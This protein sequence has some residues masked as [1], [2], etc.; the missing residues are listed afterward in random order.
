[1][2]DKPVNP[3]Y[4]FWG[5]RLNDVPD[6]ERDHKPLEAM[7][8]DKRLARNTL[9]T[10]FTLTLIISTV[11]MTV[12]W[13]NENA[14]QIITRILV[15]S[16]ILPPLIFITVQIF[17]YMV[18]MSTG[19]DIVYA[20]SD[21]S[22]CTF[23]ISLNN[24]A[25]FSFII[26][27]VSAMGTAL[28]VLSAGLV[29]LVFIYAPWISGAIAVWVFVLTGVYIYSDWLRRKNR[30]KLITKTELEGEE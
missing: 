18:I 23:E 14:K 29:I 8:R 5:N 17:R 16:A 25:F 30:E 1:M 22:Y 4:T 21:A 9:I 19:C 13:D 6:H 11:I 20:E 26:C 27:I 2:S 7:V 3:I 12:I 10:L 28:S 15:M 24:V